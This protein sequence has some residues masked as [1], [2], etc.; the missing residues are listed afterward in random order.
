[1]TQA[2]YAI[3]HLK[4]NGTSLMVTYSPNYHFNTERMDTSGRSGQFQGATRKEDKGDGGE[5][6]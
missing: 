6:A 4:T 3:E 1:M 5:G 2:T